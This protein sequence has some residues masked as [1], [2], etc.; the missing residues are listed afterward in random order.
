MCLIPIDFLANHGTIKHHLTTTTSCGR[1]FVTDM[2]TTIVN[3]VH[4]RFRLAHRRLNVLP[5]REWMYYIIN[6]DKPNQQQKAKK[7]VMVHLC[8]S[9]TGCMSGGGN[10]A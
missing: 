10:R 2:T 1:H 4:V 6:C 5:L 7:C 9:S 3:I 8:Y